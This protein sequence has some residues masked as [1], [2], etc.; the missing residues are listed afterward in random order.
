M[1]LKTGM[2][3]SLGKFENQPILATVENAVPPEATSTWEGYTGD[4]RGLLLEMCRKSRITA[5]ALVKIDRV[6]ADGV[7]GCLPILEW[8]GYWWTTNGR[9]IDITR[10]DETGEKEPVQ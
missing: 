7:P 3:I 1:E 2:R 9:R 10:G 5:L 4:D 6:A 8:R